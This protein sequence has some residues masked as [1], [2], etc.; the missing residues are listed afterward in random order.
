MLCGVWC[1]LVLLTF[2]ASHILPFW[3]AIFAQLLS[4]TFS[5]AIK[6]QVCSI[7]VS[8]GPLSG[9]GDLRNAY[10]GSVVQ[11]KVELFPSYAV[12]SLLSF[13]A[14]FYVV[15]QSEREHL[16]SQGLKPDVGNSFRELFQLSH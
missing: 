13:S 2:T 15:F 1:C 9:I 11:V 10:D 4:D 3:A 16:G 5:D 6:V 12:W 7:F 8:V 14:L